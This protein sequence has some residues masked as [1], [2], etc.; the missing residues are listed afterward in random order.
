M[1]NCL[2]DVGGGGGGLARSVR[3]KEGLKEHRGEALRV[4]SLRRLG[5]G[6]GE[7]I[8]KRGFEGCARRRRAQG[9]ENGPGGL[10]NLCGGDLQSWGG[11]GSLVPEKGQG[12][13]SSTILNLEPSPI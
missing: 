4:E 5:T 2:G 6:Q 9:S 12:S 7:D 3:G 10:R 8:I 13:G 11:A 1:Q